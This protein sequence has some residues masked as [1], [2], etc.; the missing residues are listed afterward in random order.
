MPSH[1]TR[2]G[3]GKVEE[4]YAKEVAKTDIRKVGENYAKPWNKK[5]QR[6]RK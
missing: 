4:N 5:R 2:Y 3:G 1:G 6:E